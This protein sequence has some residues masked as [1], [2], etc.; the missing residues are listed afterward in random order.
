MKSTAHP[1]QPA[2]KTAQRF[3]EAEKDFRK[4]Q[5]ELRPFLRQRRI[6]RH[7][8]AGRWVE[9]SSLELIEA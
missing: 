1:K 7:T 6:E 5:E 3:R 2:A 4:I 8:T 9:T